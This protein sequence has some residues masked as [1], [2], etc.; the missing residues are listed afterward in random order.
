MIA[1]D[2]RDDVHHLRLDQLEAFQRGE[3]VFIDLAGDEG[4]REIVS[5]VSPIEGADETWPD[6]VTKGGA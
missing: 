2:D 4:R 6:G 3:R 5:L 1:I